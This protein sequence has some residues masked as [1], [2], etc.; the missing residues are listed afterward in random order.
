MQVTPTEGLPHFLLFKLLQDFLKKPKK[1]KNPHNSPNYL[2]LLSSRKDVHMRMSCCSVRQREGQAG[3]LM[4]GTTWHLLVGF[5]AVM[6]W[7]SS[8]CSQGTHTGQHRPDPDLVS[9]V[10]ITNSST[11]NRF[12]V[13]IATPA[14]LGKTFSILQSQTVFLYR[15]SCFNCIFKLAWL[16]ETKRPWNSAEMAVH[17][18]APWLY[19]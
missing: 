1:Q 9:T 10:W 4:A 6:T 19:A 14:G 13:K 7:M 18:G 3:G 16:V 12:L 11:Y 2:F 8:S 5:C 17:T 15:C